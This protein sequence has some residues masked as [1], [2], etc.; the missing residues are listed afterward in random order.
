LASISVFLRGFAVAPALPIF[1]RS[2]SAALRCGKEP[3]AQTTPPGPAHKGR[4]A[5]AITVEPVRKNR[6]LCLVAG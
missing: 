2:G 1:C 5:A 6:R 4:S 3:Q